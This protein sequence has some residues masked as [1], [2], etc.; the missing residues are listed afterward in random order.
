V[1]EVWCIDCF[2]FDHLLVEQCS[3]FSG[4]LYIGLVCLKMVPSDC[5]VFYCFVVF[6]NVLIMVCM[7]SGIV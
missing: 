3:V 1:F 7:S 4:V 2:M 5:R 6:D